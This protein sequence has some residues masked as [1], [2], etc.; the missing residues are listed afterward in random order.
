MELSTAHVYMYCDKFKELL[1]FKIM[2]EIDKDEAME[3]K[4]GGE[5]E[6]PH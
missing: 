2:A 1:G 6:A 3:D 5:G 4:W